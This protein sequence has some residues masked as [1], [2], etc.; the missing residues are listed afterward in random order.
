MGPKREGAGPLLR[1]ETADPQRP[2]VRKD[3]VSGIQC[4]R[5]TAAGLPGPAEDI[6]E[7]RR[8]PSA[9]ATAGPPGV[10]PHGAAAR[11]LAELSRSFASRSGREA[12]VS[13][14]R[15][16]PQAQGAGPQAQGAGPG[17]ATP[18]AAPER[19][20]TVATPEAGLLRVVAG[21]RAGA[22]Q[23]DWGGPWRRRNPAKVGAGRSQTPVPERTRARPSGAAAGPQRAASAVTP[24]SAAFRPAPPQEHPSP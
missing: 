12:R 15:G 8:R 17:A 2:H 7:L 9:A 1:P 11:S 18:H 5:P 6:A 14:W 10:E 19:D 21:Q 24:T 13:R 22:R 23:R 20:A 16:T 4:A 3:Q